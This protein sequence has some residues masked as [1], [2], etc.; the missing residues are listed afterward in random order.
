MIPNWKERELNPIM[1]KYASYEVD[2]SN[3][4]KVPS[5]YCTADYDNTQLLKSNTNG[6][7]VDYQFFD[8]KKNMFYLDV[9]RPLSN[10]EAI[11]ALEI[12]KE[13]P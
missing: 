7:K 1:T 2:K 9:S 3:A 8:N 6:W 10:D 12:L 5:Y 13:S 11:K 4:K